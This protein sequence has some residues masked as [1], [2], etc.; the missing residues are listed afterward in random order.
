M[1]LLSRVGWGLDGL[2]GE[3][4][5][6]P[7]PPPLPR[8]VVRGRALCDTGRGL[9]HAGGGGEGGEEEVEVEGEEEGE[10]V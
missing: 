7:S 9:D 8:A 4:S 6:P 10:G 5:P 2:L 1:A 3:A